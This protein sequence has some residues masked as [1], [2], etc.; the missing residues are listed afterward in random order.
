MSNP[1]V[2]VYVD[3]FNLYY[4]SLKGSDNKWLNLQG[5]FEDLMPGFEIKRIRYFTARVKARP[6]DPQAAVRQGA[7]LRALDTLPKVSVHLGQFAVTT[8]RMALADET[9]VPRT[10]EVIKTEEKGS[11]VNLAAHLLLDAFRDDA[12]IYLVASNDSDLTEPLRM[13][14]EELNKHVGIAKT[15]ARMSKSLLRCKPDFTRDIRDGLLR[16]NQ[17]EDIITDDRGMKIHK[18]NDWV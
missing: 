17:F 12:D 18:P 14:R 4:G 15:H 6:D 11:D 8:T 2:N 9:V 13:V 16:S 5:V 7:Y 1:L 10:V 3:G